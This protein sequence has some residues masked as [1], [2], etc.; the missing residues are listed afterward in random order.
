MRRVKQHGDPR[1][2]A[3]IFIV[4]GVLAI[5]SGVIFLIATRRKRNR[6]RMTVKA[7]VVSNEL[8]H[9]TVGTGRNKSHVSAYYPMFE[10]NFKK[11]KI[12]AKGNIGS[13]PPEYKIGDIVEICV[14]PDNPREV[15]S[16]SGK[17][18]LIISI[19]LISFGLLFSTIG[20]LLAAS[21]F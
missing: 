17:I 12:R 15:V 18:E 5:L 8:V 3:A 4:L 2:G 7:K 14:N 19:F 10:F 21:L 1:L 6:C 20:G 16:G 9:S 13:Y 11:E